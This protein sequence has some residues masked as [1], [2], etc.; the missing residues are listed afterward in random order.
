MSKNK[1]HIVGNVMQSEIYDSNWKVRVLDIIR[2]GVGE[3]TIKCKV[4]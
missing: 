1:E 2:N 4:D 3:Q